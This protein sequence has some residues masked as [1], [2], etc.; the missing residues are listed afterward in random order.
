MSVC[1]CETAYKASVGFRTDQSHEPPLTSEGLADVTSA[2]PG[3]AVCNASGPGTL[4]RL[5]LQVMAH[6]TH[7]DCLL[8]ALLVGFS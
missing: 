3:S 8:P 6:S 7:T 1:I 2:P 5:F 4:R